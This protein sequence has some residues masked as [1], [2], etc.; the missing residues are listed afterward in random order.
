MFFSKE[1]VNQKLNKALLF[2][3]NVILEPTILKEVILSEI[4]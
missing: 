3:L 2:L 1:K 4:N